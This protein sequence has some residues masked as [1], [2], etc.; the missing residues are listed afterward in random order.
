LEGYK[1]YPIHH[2]DN[3][4]ARGRRPINGIESFWSFAKLRQA[5]LKAVRWEH[6]YDH[7]KET[8]WRFNHRRDT[9]FA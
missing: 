3:Q 4:F 1:H 2:H 9:L 6:F 7:L 8:E 5:R